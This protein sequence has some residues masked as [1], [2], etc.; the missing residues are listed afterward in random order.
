MECIDS[1]ERID[2]AGSTKVVIQYKY[3]RGNHWI[4][5]RRWVKFPTS[6]DFFP[7][8]KGLLM[9]ID[10]WKSLLPLLNEFIDKSSRNDS[11]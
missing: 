9:S 8:K 5:V 2:P 3:D 1:T 7:T 10:S 11:K 4:D 6:N